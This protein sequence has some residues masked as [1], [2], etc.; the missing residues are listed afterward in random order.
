MLAAFAVAQLIQDQDQATLPR[1]EYAHLLKLALGLRVVVA[2][3]QEHAR[4]GRTERLGNV[5]ISG[6]EKPR[7]ALKD[8]VLDVMTLPGQGLR[9]VES[10]IPGRGLG[11]SERVPK[12]PD[13]LVPIAFP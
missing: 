9:D 7:A 11:G 10:E 6:D 5:E 8:H 2:V 12:E 13:L 3:D 4:H 1:P